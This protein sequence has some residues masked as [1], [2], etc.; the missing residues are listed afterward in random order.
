MPSTIPREFVECSSPRCDLCLAAR[1]RSVQR[2]ATC[3]RST[4]MRSGDLGGVR[5]CDSSDTLEVLIARLC[6]I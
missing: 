6:E 5:V 3:S 2:R 1:G 4:A